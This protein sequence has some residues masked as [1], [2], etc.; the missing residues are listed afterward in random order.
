MLIIM[1]F[2]YKIAIY[3]NIRI[4]ILWYNNMQPNE[5]QPAKYWIE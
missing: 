1:L 3:I 5:K 4:T 2:D